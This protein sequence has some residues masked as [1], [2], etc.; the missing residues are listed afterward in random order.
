LPHYQDGA[1]YSFI[2]QLER[3]AGFTRDNTDGAKLGKP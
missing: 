1:L 2:I 3:A